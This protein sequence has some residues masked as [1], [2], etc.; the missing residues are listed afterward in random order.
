MSLHAVRKSEDALKFR[1]HILQAYPMDVTW[2]VI[3]PLVPGLGWMRR[4]RGSYVKGPAISGLPLFCP[5]SYP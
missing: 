4:L 3:V 2:V 1:D 5:Q